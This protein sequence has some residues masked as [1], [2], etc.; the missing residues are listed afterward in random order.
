MQRGN[1]LGSS[2]LRDPRGFYQPLW[3][4]Q[5]GREKEGKEGSGEEEK[6]GP[7]SVP[8]AGY[9]KRMQKTD[10]KDERDRENGEGGNTLGDE[11]LPSL[12]GPEEKNNSGHRPGTGLGTLH[13]P[14]ISSSQIYHEK[15]II[16]PKL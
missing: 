10:E 4:T 15:G 13:N 16:T 3:E 14:L 5:I 11:A 9:K 8:W 1:Q 12:I 7:R 2:G 6:T